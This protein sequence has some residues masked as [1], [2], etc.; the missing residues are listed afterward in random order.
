MKIVDFK[1]LSIENSILYKRIPIPL[2]IEALLDEPY[3]V[4]VTEVRKQFAE[5]F[6]N[7][8]EYLENCKEDVIFIIQTDMPRIEL[9]P[10]TDLLIGLFVKEYVVD[11]SSYKH[12]EKRLGV[13]KELVKIN[14][15]DINL[16]ELVN[17][18]LIKE[19]FI[20]EIHDSKNR[21]IYNFI[22]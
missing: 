17:F 9:T 7:N 1:T 5:F 3:S 14:M 21:S 16:M 13:P 2:Q 4:F 6:Q 12:E 19:R 15:T 18:N 20:I 11:F 22:V 8:E 10:I